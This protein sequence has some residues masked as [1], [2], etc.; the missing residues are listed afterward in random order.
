MNIIVSGSSRGIGL[1]LA[2]LFCKDKNNSVIGISRHNKKYAE[3]FEFGENSKFIPFE[4]DLC[5]IQNNFKEKIAEHIKNVDILINNAGYLVNKPI[6]KLSDDDFD[7][8]FNINI[9]SV[10]K[11][12]Q[13]LLPLFASNAHIVN[14]SSMGGYQG[15][16]KFKGL[17]LYS[18]SKGALNTL[19]ECLAEELKEHNI[20]INSLS[21]GAVN[22]EMLREAF[23]DYKASI[24]P[25]E[26][27]RFIKHFAENAHHYMNGKIL[28]VSLTTP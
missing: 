14:I 13:K 6:E 3:F 11:I 4:Y 17:S 23:P 16:T 12:I 15:S 26:M 20:K 21:L 9:K 19:T 5:S 24:Q 10:F 2:K 8:M 27:A 25:F 28:P 1:E 18:A 7:K 22:T